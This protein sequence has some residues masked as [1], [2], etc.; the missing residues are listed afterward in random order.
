MR[1][2]IT[3]PNG[4]CDGDSNCDRYA[5]GN[6][7]G[8]TDR[9]YNGHANSYRYGKTHSKPETPSHTKASSDPTPS[10]VTGNPHQAFKAGQRRSNQEPRKGGIE[11]R[12][13]QI[14]LEYLFSE[15][16]GSW[17]PY[18]KKFRAKGPFFP[19]SHLAG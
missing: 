5:H 8:N 12:G 16:A 18:S 17:L 19:D 9:N 2:S 7:D 1:D 15:N 6:R 14:M 10:T 13:F 11:E 4:Y 3:N